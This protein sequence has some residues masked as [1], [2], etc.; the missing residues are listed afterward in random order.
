MRE[1]GSSFSSFS[2]LTQVLPAQPSVYREGAQ[3]LGKRIWH[4]FQ[5]HETDHDVARKPNP[6]WPKP[7]ENCPHRDGSECKL[8][9]KLPQ[10][11]EVVAPTDR[12]TCWMAWRPWLTKRVWTATTPSSTE[13]T[14]GFLHVFCSAKGWITCGS[15]CCTTAADGM[16]HGVPTNELGRR[17]L[18]GPVVHRAREGRDNGLVFVNVL[19]DA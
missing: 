17:V 4:L 6:A 14:D 15:P 10:S 3:G 18:V 13:E 2:G 5:V 11:V 7:R 8:S 19:R 9:I 12:A 16:D 1:K